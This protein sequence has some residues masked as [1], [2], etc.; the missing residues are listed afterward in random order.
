VRKKPK[1]ATFRSRSHSHWGRLTLTLV[2]IFL[3]ILFLY[4]FGHQKH[5]ATTLE[6]SAPTKT[7]VVLPL[8]TVKAKPFV[9]KPFVVPVE[10]AEKEHKHSLVLLLKGF[11]R[12]QSHVAKPLEI[13]VTEQQLPDVTKPVVAAIV[14]PRVQP[15]KP[16]PVVVAR[17]QPQFDFYNILPKERV[18]IAKQPEAGVQY[19]LQIASFKKSEDADQLKSQLAL[20]GFDAFTDKIRRGG[21]SVIRVN[22]GP[23]FSLDAATADQKRLLTSNIK[24]TLHKSGA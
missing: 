19:A 8:P 24:S 16:N 17:P 1:A 7:E 2:V 4:H 10:V 11:F 22:V 15:T 14:Q 18:E 13:P 21:E 3:F 5:V 20:L 12:N 6:I 9:V 23:Y